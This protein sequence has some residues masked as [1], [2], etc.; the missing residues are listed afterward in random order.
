MENISFI[1]GIMH[2]VRLLFM[3]GIAFVIF[4]AIVSVVEFFLV[5]LVNYK[6]K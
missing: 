2:I 6:D 5:A 3:F 1:M 4:I